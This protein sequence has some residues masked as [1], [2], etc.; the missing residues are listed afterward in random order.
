MSRRARPSGPIG[1]ST[2]SALIPAETR[3]PD[4]LGAPLDP[5]HPAPG[6][7]GPKS[8]PCLKVYRNAKNVSWL[9]Y[10]VNY[11]PFRSSSTLTTAGPRG[12]RPLD[13]QLHYAPAPAHDATIIDETELVRV[14][15]V[16]GR[17]GP[18]AQQSVLQE[19]RRAIRFGVL[20]PGTQL[21]QNALAEQLGF[22]VVPIREALPIL[23]SEGH[24]TYVPRRGYF[25]TRLTDEEFDEVHKIR[26]AL[27]ELAIQ[28]AVARMTSENF[29]A[30]EAAIAAASDED[31]TR[32]DEASRRFFF[33]IFDTA[34][35]PRLSRMI[36]TLWN[37]A[38]AFQ[39]AATSPSMTTAARVRT[40]R[41]I[42]KLA[43]AGNADELIVALDKFHH[44]VEGT[45]GKR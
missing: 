27:E 43:R 24:V 2:C 10:R 20:P 29:A 41:R 19:L 9:Q 3:R 40:Y 12:G 28:A 26:G 15:R 45:A 18:T 38:D 30:M 34:G 36:R 44:V 5:F 21:A 31:L 4:E 22:S 7:V 16:Q 42:L 17:M 6:A 1:T 33:E 14:G 37:Q 23:E 32:R 35:M 25:V 11:P 39:P 13:R 8:R